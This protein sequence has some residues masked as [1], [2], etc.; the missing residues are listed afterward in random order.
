MKGAVIFNIEVLLHTGRCVQATPRFSAAINCKN[1]R[2][3]LGNS[4]IAK[5]EAVSFLASPVKSVSG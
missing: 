1:V 2:T 4:S 5:T 3:S